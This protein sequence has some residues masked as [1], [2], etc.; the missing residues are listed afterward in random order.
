MYSSPFS[1]ST[2]GGF[3]RALASPN[4]AQSPLRSNRISP[5]SKDRFV[6]PAKSPSRSPL[7]EGTN[8]IVDTSANKR[9]STPTTPKNRRAPIAE[10]NILDAP[11]VQKSLPVKLIDF[12]KNGDLAIA[13]GTSIY[14]WSQGQV[15]ELMNGGTQF[16]AVSWCDEGLIISGNGNI[17][18]WD[19]RQ[20]VAFFAF[21]NHE[22]RCSAISAS[23]SMAATGGADG[24][25]RITDTRSGDFQE[26][27]LHPKCGEISSLAWSY[28]GRYLA[29][30]A[31]H[32]VGVFKS[33][34]PQLY[35]ASGKVQSL[36]WTQGDI[37]YAADYD[38]GNVQMIR[39]TMNSVLNQVD[40]GS[41]ISG[42]CYTD[43]WGLVTASAVTGDWSIYTPRE[44]KLISDYHGHSDG[45]INITACE[46][47]NLVATIGLDETLRIWTLKEPRGPL[48]SPSVVRRPPSPFGNFGIR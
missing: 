6:S 42:L 43:S 4:K 3:S 17:E 14:I 40:T 48:N 13:L 22:R 36:S 37:L 46:E 15:T 38:Q 24:I 19:V 41:P 33:K 21:Q 12:N 39:A 5:Y 27:K 44:L 34:Q 28:D 1:Y 2:K 30:G 18:L 23:G 29:A 32:V 35:E 10:D 26:L 25:T 20:Q 16:D 7:R 9:Q 8:S 11:D 45:I 47:R 31:N